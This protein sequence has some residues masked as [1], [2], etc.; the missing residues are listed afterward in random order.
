MP[1]GMTLVISATH[2]DFVPLVIISKMALVI[3]SSFQD[4]ILAAWWARGMEVVPRKKG[5]LS[6]YGTSHA[7]NITGNE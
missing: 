1:M 3:L 5:K 4:G 7:T 6:S 2:L